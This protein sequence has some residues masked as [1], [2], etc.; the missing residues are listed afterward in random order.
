MIT[1]FGLRTNKE[2]TAERC[3]VHLAGYFN[4]ARLKCTT[5]EKHKLA[6]W[7]A[8]RQRLRASYALAEAAKQLTRLLTGGRYPDVVAQATGG[9]RSA[10]AARPARGTRRYSRNLSHKRRRRRDK[11]WQQSESK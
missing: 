11:G 6:D 8:E 5:D 4:G 7:N 2:D 3:P 9:R 1:R 10:D